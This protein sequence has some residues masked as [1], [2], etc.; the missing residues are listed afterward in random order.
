MLQLLRLGTG[1]PPRECERY[2]GLDREEC[3]AAHMDERERDLARPSLAG[4]DAVDL[5]KDSHSSS[6]SPCSHPL[7]RQPLAW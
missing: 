4:E 3:K 5:S 1:W 6:L 7:P 2:P